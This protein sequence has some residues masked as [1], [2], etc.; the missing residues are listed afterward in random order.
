MVFAGENNIAVLNKRRLYIRVE[1]SVHIG[2]GHLTR[3]LAL[4]KI[5]GTD[6]DVEFRCLEVP[7]DL[8]K[9]FE[10]I[11]SSLIMLQDELSFFEELK[12]DDLVVLDGYHFSGDYQQKLKQ[13]GCLIILIDDLCD[14]P[15]Y[16]ADLI[17]NHGPGFSPSTY[18]AEAYSMFAL[19]IEYALLRESFLKL[20]GC[21][22]QIKSIEKIF[23]CFGGSDP[24][25]LTKR[26]IECCTEQQITRQINVVLGQSYQHLDE[27]KG[28]F[29]KDKNINIYSSLS[30]IEMCTLVASSDLAIV[31]SSSI[32]LE[33]IAAK[34]LIITGF[35]IENQRFLYE[36]T[37]DGIQI[38][39]A[40]NFSKSAIHEA[41][42]KMLNKKLPVTSKIGEE[43]GR[44]TVTLVKIFNQLAESNNL[45]LRKAAYDDLDIVFRWA[46]LPS[47]RA[48]SFSKTQITHDEHKRWF[49]DKINDGNCF[50]YIV[51]QNT[52]PIGLIRFDV[53]LRDKARISYLV[54]PIFHGKGFGTLI[55][56]KG[57]KHLMTDDK[58]KIIK[59][60]HGEVLKENLPSVKAF[61]RLGFEITE[62]KD[63]FHYKKNINII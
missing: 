49:T 22:R 52:L 19:G 60:L 27:L 54:D 63:Y 2:L 18:P 36:R 57:I 53:S 20:V 21:N 15:L 35:Y 30:E 62:I 51:E 25:N 32:L 31:P 42:N 39:G 33:A 45:Y 7:R 26:V 4:A 56:Y 10:E 29:G 17:I 46:N 37:V 3:C 23:I 44:K 43:L 61:E 40:S 13:K 50:F 11:G 24:N 59:E 1:A 6:F 16:H 8:E 38:V 34:C 47:I 41:L 12:Q 28:L 48:N 5:L 9:V 55:L 58:N 14:A